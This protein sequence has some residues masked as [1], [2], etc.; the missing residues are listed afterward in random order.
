MKEICIIL[1][2]NELLYKHGS[3]L[4]FWN[5]WS[6]EHISER[7]NRP[8]NLERMTLIILEFYHKTFLKNIWT[9][10]KYT[11]ENSHWNA[12]NLILKNEELLELALFHDALDTD[13]S[14]EQRT[15]KVHFE[16][17]A[18]IMDTLFN[19]MHSDRKKPMIHQRNLIS[20]LENDTK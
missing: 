7:W 19:I 11:L 12:D 15:D 8:K 9:F 2:T 5:C 18:E 14:S 10:K 4:S 13:S 6:F 17:P 1:I 16:E 20:F 3:S